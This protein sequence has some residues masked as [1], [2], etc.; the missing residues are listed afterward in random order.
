MIILAK[1]ETML[2]MVVGAIVLLLV[3]GYLIVNMWPQVTTLSDNIS[4]MTGTDAGTTMFQALWPVIL[5]IVV[6]VI[7]VALIFWAIRQLR[8]E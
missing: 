2:S 6:I 8:T 5:I 7:L 3:V 1:L 4:S